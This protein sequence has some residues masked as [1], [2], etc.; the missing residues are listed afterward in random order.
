MCKNFVGD[1]KRYKKREKEREH[2]FSFYLV[3]SETCLYVGGLIV[4]KDEVCRDKN[5]GREVSSICVLLETRDTSSHRALFVFNINDRLIRSPLIN[6]LAVP[7]L[8][9]LVS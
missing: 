9:S 6:S 1:A 4:T 5:L 7:N 3:L 2:C 8:R